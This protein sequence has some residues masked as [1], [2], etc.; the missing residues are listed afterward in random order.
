M[1]SRSW[2]TPSRECLCLRRVLLLTA[3]PLVRAV[4]R[5]GDILLSVDGQALKG[6]RGGVQLQVDTIA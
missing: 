1:T 4:L 5:Q 2:S 6:R 3:R